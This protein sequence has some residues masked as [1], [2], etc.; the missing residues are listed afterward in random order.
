MK[1]LNQLTYTGDSKIHGQGLF[2]RESINKGCVIG[3][4]RGNPCT[5]DGAYVLWLNEDEAIR[6]NCN[7]KYIN[8]SEQPNACYYDDMTVVAL[9]DIVQNEEITHNYGVVDW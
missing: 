6:A 5:R 7:L 9:C 2:A 1:T 3:R 8:H 4:V